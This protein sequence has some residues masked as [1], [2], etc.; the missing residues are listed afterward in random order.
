MVLRLGFY[1]AFWIGSSQAF[2][3]CFVIVLGVPSM[4][5]FCE[6]HGAVCRFGLIDNWFR[7]QLVL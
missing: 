4:A 6:K 7:F 5:A 2:G 1:H 3:G